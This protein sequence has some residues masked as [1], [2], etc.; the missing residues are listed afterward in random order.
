MGEVPPLGGSFAFS[1]QARVGYF[2]QDLLW[3]DPERTPLQIV[4]DRY[5]E[6]TQ[7]EV[8]QLLAR[9][10]ISRRHAQQSAGTLSGGEQAKVKL[11]L[12][13]RQ[14]CNF[15]ILDEPTN[16]LDENAKSALQQALTEFPGT[17]LLVSHEE[18]FY[19][20]WIHQVISLEEM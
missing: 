10:G 7:K 13:T 16:H 12:L 5:P 14:P 1:P 18:A 8:R 2:Q 20:D 4:S 15:L 19:R 11:C 17:V 9:C 6:L 3:D